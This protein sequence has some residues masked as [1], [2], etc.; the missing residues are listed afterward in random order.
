M[1]W[2]QYWKEKKAGKLPP[3]FGYGN[4]KN[5]GTQMGYEPDG[6]DAIPDKAAKQKA[7]DDEEF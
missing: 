6:V 5:Y 3:D 7:H 4:Q 1:F 2:K